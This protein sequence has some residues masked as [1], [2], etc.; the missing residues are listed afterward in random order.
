MVS[1]VPAHESLVEVENGDL[2]AVLSQP[3]AHRGSD[4]TRATGHDRGALRVGH[5]LL[6]GR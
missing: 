2:A 1:T 5:V 4:A 6:L 3:C